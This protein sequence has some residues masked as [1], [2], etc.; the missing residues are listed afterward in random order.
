MFHRLHLYHQHHRFTTCDHAP[1]IAGFLCAQRCRSLRSSRE[2]F[3]AN[4]S[5]ALAKNP[6]YSQAA[7]FAD[8]AG[9]SAHNEVYAPV[10]R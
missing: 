5:S 6:P 2:T 9:W 10:A 4:A 1:L 3:P 7:W 8:C